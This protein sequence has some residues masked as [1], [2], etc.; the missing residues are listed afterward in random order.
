MFAALKFERIPLK[1]ILLD[2]RNPRIVTQS[3]LGSQ[4]Q[5]ISYLFEHEDLETFVK[6]IANEGRN[7]GAERPYV[8]QDGSKYIVVEGN[9]R[10][11][12]YKLLTGL[13]QPPRDYAGSI[14]NISEK[15]KTSLSEVDC[16]VAPSREA[17]LPI[18]VSAHFG[19]GD[20]SKWGYLGSRKAI[21]DEWENGWS[22]AQL[23][24]A[25][26]IS[27]G[28]VKEF[29]LEYLL[30]L[31]AIS[32]SC[33]TSEKQILLNPKVAFNPPV[34]FLQTSG[35]K[36]KIGITLDA[37]ALKVVFHGS[38]AKKKFKHLIRK[39][40]TSPEKGLGATA[41][42][43]E[44]FKDYGTKAGA[45]STGAAKAGTRGAATSSSGKK[46]KSAGLKR[47][48]LF[49]YKVTVNN[50]LIKQAMWEAKNLNTRSFPASGTFLLR[51]I[52]E[53]LLKEIIDKQKANTSGRTL[54]LEGAIN[55]CLS[56]HVQLPT[57]DKKIL[58]EFLKDHIAYLNLGAHGVLI[59]N[60]DR[61]AAA[62]DTIDQF[63][64]RHV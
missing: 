54:D 8:V 19:L 21:Y 61:L 56:N 4:S 40:V 27:Q 42:Y 29:I 37:T 5:I 2:D 50:A 35:H 59:P 16:S 38:E 1:D 63:V 17:L 9:N 25:F 20:K 13:V 28:D 60:A 33:S 10:I 48:G 15:T 23:S 55:L 51:N 30:Y 62:R 57:N 45:A 12:A 47:G 3:S 64:K 7:F 6:K 11:A 58:K 36:E 41:S 34:R 22:I 46:G 49:A 44:V 26:K 32:L 43:E 53:A 39:L 31:K 14:P 18:M 52:V 24:K